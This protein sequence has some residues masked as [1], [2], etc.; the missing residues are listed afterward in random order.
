MRALVT[1]PADLD[2]GVSY[3]VLLRVP[4]DRWEPGGLRPLRGDWDGTTMRVYNPDDPTSTP[5]LRTGA[6]GL[7]VL[8]RWDSKPH[9]SFGAAFTNMTWQGAAKAQ[10]GQVLRQRDLVERLGKLGIERDPE[11]YIVNED[12]A[13]ALRRDLRLTYEELDF[14][15]NRAGA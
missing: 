8:G 5:I 6:V 9:P 1:D 10:Y 13:P 3:A 11:P 14:L 4:V 15:L 12:S 7:T 2:V